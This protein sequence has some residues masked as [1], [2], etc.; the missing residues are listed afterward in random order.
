MLRHDRRV[1]R[2]PAKIPAEL[3]GVVIRTADAPSWGVTS[4]RMRRADIARPFH[5]IAAFELDLDDIEE[6][7]RAYAPLLLPGQYFSHVTALALLG[8]PLPRW[9]DDEPLHLSVLFPRTPPRGEGVAGHS[10]RK[11]TSVT[12]RRYPVMDPA[13]AWCQSAALLSR[14]DLVAA[15]DSLVTGPRVQRTRTPG[16]TTIARLGEVAKLLGRSPGAGKVAWALTRVRPGVDSRPET[17]LRLLC[18]R[19]RLPEP[20]VDFEVAVAGGILLHADLAFPRERIV[21]DYEGDDHRVDRATWLRDLQRRELF[22]DAGYRVIRVT[23][24]DL[25]GDPEAFLV[26]LRTLLDSRRA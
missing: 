5:G 4:G 12:H 1:P 23:S 6:R 26:R 16:V 25:F 24:A 22:E 18:V 20:V 2:R 13:Y 17:L 10:L 3:T 19:A 14:E 8:A 9:F 21:L 7:C 11:F 15:G